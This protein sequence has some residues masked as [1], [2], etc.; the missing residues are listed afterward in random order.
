MDLNSVTEYDQRR[1]ALLL[2]FKSFRHGAQMEAAHDLR[3]SPSMI[4]QV[5][6]GRYVDDVKLTLLETWAR[7]N[8]EKYQ[9][10]LS[11]RRAAEHRAGPGAK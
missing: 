3:L 1:N 4:S 9:D 8:E 7:E 11:F 5:L 6:R 2:K 10:H